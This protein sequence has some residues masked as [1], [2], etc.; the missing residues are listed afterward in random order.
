MNI[1]MMNI[2]VRFNRN[3]PSL[4]C[5]CK[6]THDRAGAYIMRYLDGSLHFRCFR[7]SKESLEVLKGPVSRRKTLST[8]LTSDL[9][10]IS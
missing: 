7:N 1:K 10:A 2:K 6:R 3:M 4:C 5:A 8:Q 9:T